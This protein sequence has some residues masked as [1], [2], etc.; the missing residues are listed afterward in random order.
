MDVHLISKL[1]EKIYYNIMHMT[2]FSELPDILYVHITANWQVAMHKVKGVQHHYT[3][4]AQID[5]PRALMRLEALEEHFRR[6]NLP[7]NANKNEGVITSIDVTGE[8]NI[9]ALLRNEAAQSSIL[10][11]TEKR[12]SASVALHPNQLP[13]YSPKCRI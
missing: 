10:E 1:Y 12:Q 5:N 11:L 9:D 13:A 6:I 4:A 3:L 8:E 7:Y 2:N